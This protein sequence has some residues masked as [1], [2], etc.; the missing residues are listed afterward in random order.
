MRFDGAGLDGLLM[1]PA[2]TMPLCAIGGVPEHPPTRFR[3]WQLVNLVAGH[4]AY[5]LICNVSI[6]PS[7]S[8]TSMPCLI[9]EVS[10]IS[11]AVMPNLSI[12]TFWQK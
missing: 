5:Q 10:N 2:I 3:E 12:M 7:L 9:Q 4:A 11:F 6:R 1:R 8:S